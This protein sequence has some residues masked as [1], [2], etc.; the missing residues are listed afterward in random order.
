MMNPMGKDPSEMTPQEQAAMQQHFMDALTENCAFRAFQGGVAGALMGGLFG[1]FSASMDSSDMY[2]NMEGMTNRQKFVSTVRT[3]GQRT[4]SMA[5]G[6]GI[7]SV[8]FSGFECLIEK[9]RGKTDNINKL[10]SGC[11]TGAGAGLRSGPHGMVIGC[12]GV[13]AMGAV[14]DLILE[15]EDVRLPESHLRLLNPATRGSIVREDPIPEETLTH[16][17]FTSLPWS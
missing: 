4:L 10:L 11:I 15:H 6:L 8:F 3:M 2:P 16:E 7:F 9:K 1:L 13:S 14:F 17:V 5:K 12:V